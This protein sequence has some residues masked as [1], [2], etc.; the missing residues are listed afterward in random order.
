MC[1]KCGE[2]IISNIREGD[3]LKTARGKRFTITEIGGNIICFRV[4]SSG[5][6]R[7][8]HMNHLVLCYHWVEFDGKEIEGV[9]GSTSHSVRELVGSN[10]LLTDCGNCDRN[11]AYIWGMLNSLPKVSRLEKN[12]LVID[13][14]AVGTQEKSRS[15]SAWEDREFKMKK[16][17]ELGLGG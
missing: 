5:K 10:G 15:H 17:K 9:G 8:I 3:Q 4:E 14:D 1:E 7:K 6:E 12:V 16:L 2:T 11:P 13:E